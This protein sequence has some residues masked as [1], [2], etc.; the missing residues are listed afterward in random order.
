MIYVDDTFLLLESSFIEKIED[1]IYLKRYDINNKE[2]IE[3]TNDIISYINHVKNYP[4][5]LKNIKI[6]NYIIYHEDVRSITFTDYNDFI[7]C[8]GDDFIIYKALE[9]G[10]IDNINSTKFFGT[11]NYFLEYIPELYKNNTYRETS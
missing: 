3:L 9:Q 10:D 4:E 2:L 5:H 1:I 7:N 6:N 11:T 8:I